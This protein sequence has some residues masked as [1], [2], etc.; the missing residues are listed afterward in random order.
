[1]SDG[2][3]VHGGQPRAPRLLWTEPAPTRDV[4][5]LWDLL[6]VVFLLSGVYHSVQLP[7]AVWRLQRENPDL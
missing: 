6:A 1:M 4:M 5:T 2:G 7:R 3:G